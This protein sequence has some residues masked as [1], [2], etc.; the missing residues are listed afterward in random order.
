MEKNIQKVRDGNALVD[1]VMAEIL[2]SR[3]S[4][5]S[6]ND[7]ESYEIYV[8][9]FQE[10]IDLRWSSLDH[11]KSVEFYRATFDRLKMIAQEYPEEFPRD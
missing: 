3:T 2:R 10:W 6:Q 11:T 1:R 8:S 5:F 4:S 7:S 9:D